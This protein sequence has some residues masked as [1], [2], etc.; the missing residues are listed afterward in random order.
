MVSL[1]FLLFS[2][3]YCLICLFY[4]VMHEIAMGQVS[5]LIRT[6]S[7]PCA[8]TGRGKDM[9]ILFQARIFW[10]AYATEGIVTGLYGGRL[11]L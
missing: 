6:T 7:F 9:D 4:Q 5:A 8:I 3:N 11:I 1:H 10:Y 2:R